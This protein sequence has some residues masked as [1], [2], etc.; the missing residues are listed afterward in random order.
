MHTVYFTSKM[1]TTF[2]IHNFLI[3]IHSS[4]TLRVWFLI[5]WW[6]HAW[7]FRPWMKFRIIF[8]RLDSMIIIFRLVSM[9]I[10]YIFGRDCFILVLIPCRCASLRVWFLILWWRHAWA[11]RPWMKF[12]IIIFRLDSMIIIFRLVSMT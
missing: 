9:T 7:A 3:I 2:C 12:R 4:N 10:L 8:F 5:L 6:R 1:R 11:F